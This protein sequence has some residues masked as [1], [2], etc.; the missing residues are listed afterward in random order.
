M[1]LTQMSNM[2]IFSA[3]QEFHKGHGE[4]I[5]QLNYL[6]NITEVKDNFALLS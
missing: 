4:E 5:C 2:F 3:F 1:A 6:R